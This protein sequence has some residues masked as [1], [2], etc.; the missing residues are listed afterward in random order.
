MNK[1]R[2]WVIPLKTLIVNDGKGLSAW[3]RQD[4]EDE[5]HVIEYS[6]VL[7][8][9]AEIVKLKLQLE[10]HQPF[11][12]Y[13]KNWEIERGCIY[14]ERAQLVKERDELKAALEKIKTSPQS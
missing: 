8:L 3:I 1:P 11:D 5:I 4:R 13:Y 10:D 7:E 6:R 12:A 14:T 2:E 9:E